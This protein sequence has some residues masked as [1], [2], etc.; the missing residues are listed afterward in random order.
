M[1]IMIVTHDVG[2]VSYFV[3]TIACVN[4]YLHYHHSN[5]ITEEQL[6]A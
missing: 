5:I 3:K 2:T 1:A 6:A 4:T